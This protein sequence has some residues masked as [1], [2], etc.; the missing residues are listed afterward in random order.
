M[1]PVVK[2]RNSITKGKP[3]GGMMKLIRLLLKKKT[4]LESVEGRVVAKNNTYSPNEMWNEQFTLQR[5]PLK[6]R[7]FSDLKPGMGR[8]LQSWQKQ[9]RKRRPRCGWWQMCQRCTHGNLSF[10][11]EAKNVAWKQHYE[12]LLNEEFSWNPEDLT[13]DPVVGPPSTV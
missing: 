8:H 7:S 1:R 11:N 4:V 3:G 13:V 10:N 9:L 2:R 12:R 5:R 6:R